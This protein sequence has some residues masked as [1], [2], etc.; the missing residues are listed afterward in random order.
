MKIT[1]TTKQQ[2]VNLAIAAILATCFIVMFFKSCTGEPVIVQVKTPEV[3]GSFA[4]VAPIH[5]TIF[6]TKTVKSVIVKKGTDEFAQAEITRLLAE[7][8]K[9][10][11]AFANANDSLQQIIY[12]KTIAAKQFSHTF[13]NDTLNATV[14][15]IVANG[16]VDKLKLNYKIKSRK[17]DVKMPQTV[18]RLLGGIEVGN[19]TQL[20]NFTTK[21]NVGFQNKKGNIITVGVDTDEQFYLGYCFSIF[22][23]KR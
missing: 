7:Y 6:L 1:Q 11:E 3:N 18:F 13:D 22:S 16:N 20:D 17:V 21:A 15:G 9:L 23:V 8:D 5:D 10:N 2:K 19:T 14:K 12:A 4:P